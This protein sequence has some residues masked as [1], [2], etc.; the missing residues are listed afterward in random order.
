MGTKPGF[1]EPSR[2][3]LSTVLTLT[4]TAGGEETMHEAFLSFLAAWP[5]P[6]QTVNESKPEGP[7]PARAL[8]GSPPPLTEA[9]GLWA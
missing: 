4:E 3:A 2:Q 5:T 9:P 6:A 8:S 7:L 1:S